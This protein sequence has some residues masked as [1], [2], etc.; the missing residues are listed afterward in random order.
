MACTLEEWS[1]TSKRRKDLL[2]PPLMWRRGGGEFSKKKKRDKRVKSHALCFCNSVW[3]YQDDSR[4]SWIPG[5][6][7]NSGCV[8][9]VKSCSSSRHLAFHFLITQLILI[10]TPC[11]TV[12]TFYAR[13]FFL[14]CRNEVLWKKFIS[15]REHQ[16]CSK[17]FSAEWE[18]PRSVTCIKIP[19]FGSS[20]GLQLAARK[21]KLQMLEVDLSQVNISGN[22]ILY[23]RFIF[24]YEVL[25]LFDIGLFLTFSKSKLRN[26]TIQHTSSYSNR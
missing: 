10:Y 3:N 20:A 11:T 21:F 24:N 13:G 17:T 23:Q 9:I 18:I 5:Q 1:Y 6:F 14:F 7:L 12:K 26:K 22:S 25:M 19:V 8:Y 4:G 16:G 15:S 2:V